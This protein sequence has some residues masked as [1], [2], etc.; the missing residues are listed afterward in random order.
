META[1]IYLRPQQLKQQKK[2]C[3]IARN[4]SIITNENFI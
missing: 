3:G 1:L 4:K 2:S